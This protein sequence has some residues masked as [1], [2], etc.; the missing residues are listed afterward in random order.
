VAH[1]CE[2]TRRKARRDSSLEDRN[3]QF[4][5]VRQVQLEEA[6]RGIVVGTLNF[7]SFL[8]LSSGIVR[9][10]NILDGTRAS[11]AQAV[12]ESQFTGNF[13]HGELALGMVD[14]VDANRREPNR[15]GHLVAEEGGGLSVGE[16]RCK[17]VS[18][19]CC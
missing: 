10:S 18:L 7:D 13:R 14:L 11:C 3:S 6:D 16:M 17:N 8:G 19:L 4:I 9:S 1:R 12:W 5:I 15:G 2:D